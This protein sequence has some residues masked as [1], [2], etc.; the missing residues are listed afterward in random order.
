MALYFYRS[1]ASSREIYVAGEFP[2][3]P[4]CLP[5]APLNSDLLKTMLANDA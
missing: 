5:K 1:G 4:L 3:S 2:K